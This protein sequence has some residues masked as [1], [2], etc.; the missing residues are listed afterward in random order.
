MYISRLSFSAF[1][2]RDKYKLITK[3]LLRH[4]IIIYIYLL[5]IE[6]VMA[7]AFRTYEGARQLQAI[8]TESIIT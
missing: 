7:R 2:I 1:Q 8:I 6:D 4:Y 5:A 3:M